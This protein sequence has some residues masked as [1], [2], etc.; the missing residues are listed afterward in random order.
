MNLNVEIPETILTY[1]IK[2]VNEMIN[3]VQKQGI[4]AQ[5]KNKVEEIIVIQQKIVQL[6]TL[7]KELANDIK[8]RIV[9]K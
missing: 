1:K 7:R 3:D 5:N 8:E 6:I 2:K 4:E 9:L